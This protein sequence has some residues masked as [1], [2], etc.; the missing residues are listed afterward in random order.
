MIAVYF[1]D[2]RMYAFNLLAC[3]SPLS[4]SPF[5]FS[6][7]RIQRAIFALGVVFSLT[8]F[9]F[10]TS[11]FWK[12]SWYYIMTSWV[13]FLKLL[14]WLLKKMESLCL[15]WFFIQNHS[16]WLKIF[17]SH[18]RYCLLEIK[19]WKDISPLINFC[20]VLRFWKLQIWPYS[21]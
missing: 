13:K 7:F 11:H 16:N 5:R 8:V 6:N 21:G 9:D 2:C 17:L 18:W 14:F 1:I 19:I 4:P 10:L 15:G 12:D 3:C 20:K